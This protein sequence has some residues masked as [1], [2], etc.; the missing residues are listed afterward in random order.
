MDLDDKHE[1]ARDGELPATAKTLWHGRFTGGPSESLLA[2]TVS[3]PYDQRMWRDDIVGSRAHVRGLARVGLLTE[4]ELT[5]ILGALDGLGCG[6]GRERQPSP[7]RRLSAGRAGALCG[8]GCGCT[9][10][11][12]QGAG[13]LR[14][15][16][17]ALLRLPLCGCQEPG[18]AEALP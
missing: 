13:S 5:S 1:F 6:A 12:Q 17:Q 15:H 4:E 14:R 7:V 11:H 16:Q 9:R 2:Y 10:R 8:E 18:I 3:L